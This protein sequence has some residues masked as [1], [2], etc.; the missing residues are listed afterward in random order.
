MRISHISDS[1]TPRSLQKIR[2]ARICSDICSP[3]VLGLLALSLAAAWDRSWPAALIWILALGV[4]VVLIPML[5]LL[6]L[7]RHGAIA[8]IH[9]PRRQDRLRP[10]L[11]A[12]SCTLIG[13]ALTSTLPAPSILRI[14]VAS[15]LLSQIVLLITTL[16]WQISYHAASSAG[17]VA[18]L[19]LLAGTAFWPAIAL[20]PLV[21]W[22]RV[23]LQRHTWSQ[24]AAGALVGV[25]T[26]LVAALVEGWI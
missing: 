17:L 9:V 1:Y 16:Y 7:L 4:V 5:Y 19:T 18:L 13:L 2:L 20:L 23:T 25:S 3:P 26:L 6:S 14:L 8:D 15:Q 11:V 12:L 22:S 24:V 10:S 21:G